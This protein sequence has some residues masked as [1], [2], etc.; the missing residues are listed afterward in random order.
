MEAGGGRAVSQ[1]WRPV[2]GLSGVSVMV[3]AV[4]AGLSGGGR[5]SGLSPG[6]VSIIGKWRWGTTNPHT[7]TRGGQETQRPGFGIS[8]TLLLSM[9]CYGRFSNENVC[10]CSSWWEDHDRYANRGV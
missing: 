6:Q 2:E 5:G 1:R 7:R 10:W 9:W 3:G 4:E 8:A